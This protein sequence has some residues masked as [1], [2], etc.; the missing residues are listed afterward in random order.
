MRRLLKTT[1]LV[2]ALAFPLAACTAEYDGGSGATTTD[3]AAPANQY[4]AEPITPY[5]DEDIALN[6]P[7]SPADNPLSTFGMD[8]DTASYEYAR[9]SLLDGRLPATE[10]IRPEEFVNFFRTDYAEPDGDGFSVTFD[11]VELPPWYASGDATHLLRVGLQTRSEPAAER[12]DVN[13]TFVID[14]SGSMSGDRIQ[15]VRDSLHTL[16]DNL[17]PSDAVAIVTFET[18][19]KILR[20]MTRVDDGAEIHK[21]IDKL[22]AGGS[23]NMHA[24][25]VDG[26]DVAAD[27]FTV[28]N[29]NRV[30]LLS[31]GAANV[32]LTEH[33]AILD[34]LDPHIADGITLLTVGVGNEYNQRI[35]EQ[36][37]DNG[38]G[39]AAYFANATQ[40]ERVFGERFTTSLGVTARDAK[41]QV[42]F[43]PATVAEYRL[44]GYEN[45]MLADHEFTDDTVPG[46]SIGPGH[47]VTALYAIA[48]TGEN[49]DL[50]DVAVRWL[51]PDTREADTASG[52]VS[53]ADLGTFDDASPRFGVAAVAAAFA[54]LLRGSADGY[55]YTDLLP[56]AEALAVATEDP[57]V[58]ELA[59]LIAIASDLD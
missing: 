17:R 46:G 36:L 24:G 9:G 25:L 49:G 34:E 51:D 33:D 42:E 22:K 14:V 50:A 15:I 10:E 44:I 47:S 23:T 43:D 20:P 32:G 56:H 35:L 13:L 19:S 16:V 11:G 48:L 53:T 12:P 30:V 52:T 8:V 45:R 2:A 18:D 39:W 29:Y 21:T 28:G 5:D 58:A 31:D 4:E 26:Y 40:A 38:N 57:D 7:Q 41:V 27:G 37:A 6:A 55:G 1:S 54:E 3:H 59:E